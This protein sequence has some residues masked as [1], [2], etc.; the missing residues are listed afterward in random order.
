MAPDQEQSQ[1]SSKLAQRSLSRVQQV[2]QAIIEE[3]KK[4]ETNDVDRL[5][6]AQDENQAAAQ[7]NEQAENLNN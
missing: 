7:V 6:I 5:L 4:E 2:R 3:E 1:H